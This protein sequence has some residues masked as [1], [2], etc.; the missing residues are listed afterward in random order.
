MLVRYLA[1]ECGANVNDANSKGRTA[2]SVAASQAHIV[3]FGL[4]YIVYFA[5]IL[6]MNLG[7]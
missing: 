1:A 2:L 7:H 5:Y 3:F 4:A 6:L